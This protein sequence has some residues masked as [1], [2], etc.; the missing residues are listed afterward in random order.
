MW[1]GPRQPNWN[2]R[3]RGPLIPPSSGNDT[4]D[5][6]GTD[7]PTDQVQR[8]EPQHS[9]ESSLHDTTPQHIRPECQTAVP[10]RFQKYKCAGVRSY[11]DAVTERKVGRPH[12]GRT[13]LTKERVDLFSPDPGILTPQ[14]ADLTEGFGAT[15]EPMTSHPRK[16][17]LPAIRI[18]QSARII[19]NQTESM[20][21]PTNQAPV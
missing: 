9:A 20:E 12:E 21:A 4:P 17:W 10:I 19:I 6:G 8:T 14:E 16:D 11:R 5:S 2:K 15:P 13:T 3:L 1:R 18:I 7:L